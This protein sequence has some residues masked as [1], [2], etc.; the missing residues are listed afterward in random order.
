MCLWVHVQYVVLTKII[1]VSSFCTDSSQLLVSLSKKG[2]KG[3]KTKKTAINTEALPVE[4]VIMMWD[5]KSVCLSAIHHVAA[6]TMDSL[7]H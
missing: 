3:K 6:V 7:R 1:L 5:M 2:R 4:E